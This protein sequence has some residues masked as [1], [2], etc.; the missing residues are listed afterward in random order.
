M[1]FDKKLF[2]EDFE[3][4]T[5]KFVFIEEY[6]SNVMNKKAESI[7]DQKYVDAAEWRDIEKFIKKID[8][9]C[10]INEDRYKKIS[11]ILDENNG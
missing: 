3:K 2:Y 6:L 7:K 9:E 1:I 10:V 4:S 5:E 11:D 8:L